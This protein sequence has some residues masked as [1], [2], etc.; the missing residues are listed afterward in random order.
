[1]RGE[2]RETRQHNFVSF[3]VSP[4]FRC[5]LLQISFS[6]LRLI[7]LVAD[8][9]SSSLLSFVVIYELLLEILEVWGIT[10]GSGSRNRWW[11]MS[12]KV[13][14]NP[15]T[16]CEWSCLMC[17]RG[18]WFVCP[19]TVRS[20]VSVSFRWMNCLFPYVVFSSFSSSLKLGF[21]YSSPQNE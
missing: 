6:D 14:L 9:V 18:L 7:L 3:G 2:A 11:W 1:M 12:I 16:C 8:L 4:R 20:W 13:S 5:G 15:F 21:F 10:R 17:S 19:S